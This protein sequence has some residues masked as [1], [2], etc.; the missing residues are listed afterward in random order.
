MTLIDLR[1]AE[2][3][4]TEICPHCLGV[5]RK[6]DR[7]AAGVRMRQIRE[8]ANLSLVD[9]GRIMKKSKQYLSGLENGRKRWNTK[10]IEQ[11]ATICATGELERPDGNRPGQPGSPGV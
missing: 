1:R 3:C 10:L 11:Y 5:G 6:I 9:M 4:T 7:V 8:A 2:F